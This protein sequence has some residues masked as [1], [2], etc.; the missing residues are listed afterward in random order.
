MSDDISSKS[1]NPF[2]PLVLLSLSII[3]IF[4]WLWII[5]FQQQTSLHATKQKMEE[6]VS[7]N[8]P[9]LDEQVR[10]SKQ[11]QSGLEKLVLDLLETAKTDADAKTIVAKYNI[12]QQAPA[13]SPAPAD[14][15]SK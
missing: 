8:I 13:A 3:S 11:I 1:G 6:F 4:V 12:K 14:S 7:V 10:Q 9:K 15:G 5:I 2:I